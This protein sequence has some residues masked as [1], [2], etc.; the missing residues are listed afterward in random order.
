[1]ARSENGSDTKARCKRRPLR[2]LLAALLVSV[3]VVTAWLE[4]D[5]DDLFEL[6]ST[7]GKPTIYRSV[8]AE[9]Y[10]DGLTE[11]CWGCWR[12]LRNTDY[13]FIEFSLSK[14]RLDFDPIREPG[15]YRISRVPADSSEC[16]AE[17]TDH[18]SKAQMMR[19]ELELNNWCFQGNTE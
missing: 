9:G 10:F 4:P 15:I 13:R 7:Q 3:G 19:E 6:C 18:Y 2:W 5:E 11:N 12:Y 17:L 8:E 16:H 1:M 14:K